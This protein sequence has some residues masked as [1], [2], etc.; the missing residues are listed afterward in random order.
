[1][2]DDYLWGNSGETNSPKLGVDSF[3]N[4]FNDYLK[5]IHNEYR[6]AIQKIK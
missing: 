3:I 4:T 6:I 1:M 5:V 2:F